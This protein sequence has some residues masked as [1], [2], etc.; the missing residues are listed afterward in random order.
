MAKEIVLGNKNFNLSYDSNLNIRDIYF[1]N[2][3][4]ENHLEEDKNRIGFW[5]NGKFSWID[6]EWEKEIDYYE[7]TMVSDIK[8]K[9]DYLNIKIIEK[10]TVHYS[11]NIYVKMIE[12]EN[13]GNSEKEVKIFFYHVL[14]IYGKGQNN[15]AFY[16]P[17]TKSII[18][19]KKNRYFLFGGGSEDKKEIH[20]YSMGNIDAGSEGNYKDAEDGKLEM[21]LIAHGKIYSMLSVKSNLKPGE[22][23]KF[24]YH[25]CAGK[26][27]EEVREL[28]KFTN[29]NG[30]EKIIEENIVFW[31]SWLN[32]RTL[33]FGIYEKE[34]AKTYARS[35]LILKSHIT[36]NGGVI[37][38]VDYEHV[39]FKKDTY[40]YVSPRNNSLAAIAFDEAGYTEVTRGIFRFLKSV[41]SEDGYF[42][43]RYYPEGAIAS[44]WHAWYSEGEEI[45][46]IQ[47]DHISW[48]LIS[49]AKHYKISKDIEFIEEIYEELIKKNIK[50]LLKNIDEKTSLLKP[51]Y[52]IWEKET[53]QFFYTNSSVYEALFLIKE[54]VRIFDEEKLYI[55]VIKKSEKLKNGILNYFYDD[56]KEKFCRKVTIIDG[57][58]EREF[59]PDGSLFYLSFFENFLKCDEKI[60]KTV[61]ENVKA[62]EVKTI[63]GGYARFENDMYH[64]MT[65][66]KENIPGNPWIGVTILAGI[67]K[68]ETGNILGAK[69]I[70]EHI[71]GSAKKSGIL[72]E[73]LHPFTGEEISV[74]PYIPAHALFILFANRFL[75]SEG[76]NLI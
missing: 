63:V 68:I 33:N 29:Q 53:G 66:D 26:S 71:I 46:P 62:L 12:A 14:K 74:A 70:I 6:E 55:E 22:K 41:V 3:G 52:D 50:F 44:T 21:S 11:K 2:V 58:I 15:S 40:N 38:S 16:D 35:L 73:Q 45:L 5:V 43:N 76:I 36:S 13:C 48:V 31:Q 7:N 57:E 27:F 10:A 64:R 8:A 25:I 37:T 51:C 60:I 56:K 4:D 65:R 9:S 19:Y 54:F 69:E 1:P 61:G 20:E 23:K 24:Y 42:W 49:I 67:H 72:S 47:T 30:E 39:Q 17:K 18:H 59:T 32:K 75:K 34:I 28:A